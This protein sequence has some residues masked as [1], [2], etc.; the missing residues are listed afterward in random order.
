MPDHF[1]S[2]LSVPVVPWIASRHAPMPVSIVASLAVVAA[3]GD[4]AWSYGK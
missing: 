1:E 3:V 4:T 2:F